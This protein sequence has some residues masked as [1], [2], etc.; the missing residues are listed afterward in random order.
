[1]RLQ[2]SNVTLLLSL[3]GSELE[4]LLGPFFTISS[5]LQSLR[6]LGLLQQPPLLQARFAGWICTTKQEKDVN[7]TFILETLRFRS[8]YRTSGTQEAGTLDD[9]LPSSSEKSSRIIAGMR[10]ALACY[11]TRLALHKQDNA[12]FEHSAVILIVNNA[13]LC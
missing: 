5:H 3:Y 13:N 9:P 2:I 6:A 12:L 7:P 4:P 1:M 11:R 10:V 8:W